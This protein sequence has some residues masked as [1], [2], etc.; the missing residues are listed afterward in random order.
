M[1]QIRCDSIEKL[2]TK[3]KNFKDELED[4]NSF[5]Q[6][7]Q[8]LFRY[9]KE[10]GSRNLSVEEATMLWELSLSNRFKKL[11]EWLEFIKKE[12]KPITKDLWNQFLFF[13]RTVKDD[14]SDYD[15]D[16][17]WPLMIDDFV[18]SMKSK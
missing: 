13:V 1:N 7:Y 6:F 18:E 4:P 3:C 15:P 9:V 12:N 17:A 2:K 5:K 8:F 16:D 10:E 14:F 11:N